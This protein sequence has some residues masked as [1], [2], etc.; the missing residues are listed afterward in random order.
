MRLWHIVRTRTASL[1]FRRWREAELRE[2]LADF[3]HFLGSRPKQE[4]MV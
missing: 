1:L 4:A 2:E 3:F